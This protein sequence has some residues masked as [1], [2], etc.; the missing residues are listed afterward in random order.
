MQRATT[1]FESRLHAAAAM[2]VQ[3]LHHLPVASGPAETAM[4]A[5]QVAAD[6]TPES[7]SPQGEANGG[8]SM[9]SCQ[10]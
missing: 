4:Q 3:A 10:V 6:C 8:M 2:Y 7:Y 1:A 5:L 9:V